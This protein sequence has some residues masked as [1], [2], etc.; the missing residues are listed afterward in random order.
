MSG[1]LTHTVAVVTGASSGIGHATSLALARLGASLVLVGRDEARLAACRR[2]IEQA[3]GNARWR[4]CDLASHDE[5][6]QLASWLRHLVPSVDLLVN[7]AGAFS[8]AKSVRWIDRA[9]WD[10]VVALNLTAP[11]LPTQACVPAMLEKGAGTVITIASVAA[12]TPSALGGAAYGA[13][14]AG[15]ANLMR[16]VSTELRDQ[17]IRASTIYPGEVDSPMHLRR[18]RP[19][20]PEARATMLQPEDVA[21][22]VACIACMPARTLVEEVVITPTVRRDVR[23][24]MKIA[25]AEGPP[26][27]D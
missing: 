24:D 6:E 26:A 15:V 21:A 5:V 2:E 19:P 10:D 20:G 3:G 23:E 4:R 17:G 22:A 8:R 18:P 1:P 11:F 7:N 12:R 13:A 16:G 9:T 25:L 14:K 27:P